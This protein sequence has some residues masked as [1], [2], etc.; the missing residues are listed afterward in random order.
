LLENAPR[1][2]CPGGD[3][4]ETAQEIGK[5]EFMAEEAKDVNRK[6]EEAER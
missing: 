3:P 2:C 1:T 5:G 6:L 4:P